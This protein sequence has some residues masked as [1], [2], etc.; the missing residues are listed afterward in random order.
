MREHPPRWSVTGNTRVDL[1]WPTPEDMKCFEESIIKRRKGWSIDMPVD[2]TAWSL[3]TNPPLVRYLYIFSQVVCDT[4]KGQKGISSQSSREAISFISFHRMTNSNHFVDSSTREKPPLYLLLT[5]E[6]GISDDLVVLLAPP[7]S[8][9][10]TNRLKVLYEK[11][12]SNST[13]L[14]FWKR[15]HH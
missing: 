15:N 8:Q 14:N 12:I 7:K 4:I 1:T 10:L 9:H 3:T 5:T 11:Y 2:I 13:S 6:S